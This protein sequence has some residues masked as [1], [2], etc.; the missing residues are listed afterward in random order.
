MFLDLLSHCLVTFSDSTSQSFF[1]IATSLTSFGSGSIPSLSSTVLGYVRYRNAQ[2]EL[3]DQEEDVGALFGSLAVLQALG[4]AIIGPIVFGTVYSLTVA[5]YPK[6]V[7]LLASGVTGLAL[8]LLCSVRP[9]KRVILVGQRVLD[10]SRNRRGRSALTK[11][12]ARD[13]GHH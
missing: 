1:I 6:G 11:D 10:T 4:Q 9:R 3:L 8:L 2:G 13:I 5:T 7:F 12:I